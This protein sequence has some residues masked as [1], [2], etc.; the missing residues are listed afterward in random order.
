MIITP[1]RIRLLIIFYFHI[2]IYYILAVSESILTFLLK[3][4]KVVKIQL[5]KQCNSFCIHLMKLLIS[6]TIIVFN[7]FGLLVK[8]GTMYHWNKIL[9]HTTKRTS[10]TNEHIIFG[11]SGGE[12]SFPANDRELSQT[13]PAFVSVR[14]Q[15]A[16]IFFLANSATFR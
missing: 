3:A 7:R 14:R 12:R 16:N 10:T 13:P 6:S 9:I 11:T 8:I 2:S 4:M 15:F 1:L 5:Q